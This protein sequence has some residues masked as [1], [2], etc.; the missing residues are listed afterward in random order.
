MDVVQPLTGI[1]G[2]SFLILFCSIAAFETFRDKMASM[3]S[4]SS[5]LK[6]AMP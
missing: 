3:T 1:V 5:W 6:V 4:L 2:D